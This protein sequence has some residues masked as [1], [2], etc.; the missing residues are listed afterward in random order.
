MNTWEDELRSELHRRHAASLYRRR[1][2]RTAGTVAEPIVGTAPTINFCSNDYLGL[3]T[4]PAVVDALKAGVDHYGVG[5]GA[6]HLVTGYCEAHA[7]LEQEVA[8]FAGRERA[9]V[10]ASGYLANLGAVTALV[11]RNDL[12]VADR[13]NHASLNDAAL[14]SRA[15]LRRYAHAD[16]TAAECCLAGGPGR[17][18]LVLTDGVFSMDGDIAPLKGLAQVCSRHAAVLVVDDAHGI[19]VLG[20][21][22]R[23]TLEAL[24]LSP[25]EVPVLIG[26]FGKAFGACGAFVAGSEAL[27]ESLI[28]AARTYIYTTAPPPA[29]AE[30]VRAALQVICHEPWRRERLS[31]NISRFREGARARDLPLGT[32]PT[33]IQP[34]MLGTPERALAVSASLADRGFM[35]S[36]IR[37]P[38]VPQGTARLRITLS[39]AHSASQIDQLLDA[40]E[41]LL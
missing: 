15:R 19:G 41:E 35:V 11:G 17:R 32:S 34:L 25:A 31:T 5:A 21:G 38:T 37:P 29:L 33:P 7:R 4:H 36:A 16:A 12:V 18:K 13:L 28:Q 24:G 20:T 14:L 27:I 23:G 26:T 8:A 2:L 22:G 1:A 39:A 6:S 10:F 30:A 40:L 3:S 9:L